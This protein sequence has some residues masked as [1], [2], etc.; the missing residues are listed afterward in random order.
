MQKVFDAHIHHLFEMP[1]DEAI[2]IFKLEFPVTKTERQA[3]M[4]IPND[5]D[6]KMNFYLD[7]MQNM[8]MLFLKYVFSP[9]AYA[10]SGLEH[11]FNV[12]EL[13]EEYLSKEYLHQAEEYVLNG[14]DGMKM[15][16]GYPSLRKV[17]K[18][19]LCDK[20]YD[21]YYSFLEENGIPITMHVA[22]PEENWDISKAGE[23]A[24]KMGR[25]YDHTYPTRLEL[26]DE[27]DGIMKKHPKLKLALA[28]FGFMSYD[29]DQAKRWL[30][31]E[32]TVFDI[33]PGGEQLLNMLN[34]WTEWEKFFVEHQDR[35]IYGTDYYAF[36]QDEKW[37]ENF[38]RRPKFLREFFE[39]DSEHDYGGKVFRG[40]KLDEKILKKIYWD[41]AMRLLGNPKKINLEY[42]K[43][44]ADELLG[45]QN[46]YAKFADEDLRYILKNVR[47]KK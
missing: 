24:I 7:E 43:R 36:P 9:T 44:K 31:Y 19:K 41:N 28:H 17:M 1:I 27:V 33:T 26:L 38:L 45:K 42:M 25:V 30:D 37:E 14:F 39:T 11:P 6:S 46:K 23:Y 47:G 29:I 8:R 20:V 35:I 10:F 32:N 2:R 13:D 15:L 12:T 18:R 40:V 21:R 22:N 3:F 34:N 16:E 5:C 4:S